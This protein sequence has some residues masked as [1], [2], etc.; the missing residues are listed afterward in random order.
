[1]LE[2]IEDAPDVSSAS[3]LGLRSALRS[4]SLETRR[5]SDPRVLTWRPET[6]DASS[7]HSSDYELSEVQREAKPHPLRDVVKNELQQLRNANTTA[8]FYDPDWD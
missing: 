7:R 4:P 8:P 1:M 5:S 3:A 2:R 6:S